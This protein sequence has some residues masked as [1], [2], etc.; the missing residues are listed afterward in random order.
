MDKVKA[1][2]RDRDRDIDT[3]RE[4][5]A[6]GKSRL[7]HVFC[8]LKL[9]FKLCEYALFYVENGL[10]HSIRL[11]KMNSTEIMCVCVYLCMQCMR[12]FAG[13]KL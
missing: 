5:S 6:S 1:R 2:D 9:L 11:D 4:R 12:Q 8:I 7:V 3:D 10:L 13:S